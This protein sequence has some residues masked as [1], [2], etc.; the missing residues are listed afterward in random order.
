MRREAQVS[1][2]LARAVSRLRWHH[3]VVAAVFAAGL[4]LFGN[5]VWIKGKAVMAQFLL[6]RAF[7]TASSSRPADKPW[8]WADIRPMA[9]ITAPRLGIRNIVLDAVSGEALAF[10]PGH[11]PGTALPGETGTAVFSAHRDTHFAW[12]GDLQKGDTVL[13]ETGDGT[14][15]QYRIR[16]A[17]VARYDAP[18][19]DR[20]APERL[21][22]LTTCWPLDAIERGDLRYIVEGIE[23]D[24][25]ER[26]GQN[27]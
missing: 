2:R 25:K 21:I 6:D 18:G 12:L 24:A 16:R 27:L 26:A 14:V 5:G 4:A 19:I 15:R 23:V 10:G 22:A 3:A 1:S 9:R 17:W 8:G 20:D 7:L 13:V 11:V